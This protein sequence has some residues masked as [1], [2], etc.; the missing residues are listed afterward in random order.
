MKSILGALA[1]L[2]LWSCVRADPWLTFDP[3]GTG[4][5]AKRIVL[6]AGDEEYRSEEALPQL[7]RILSQR[8]GFHCDVLVSQDADGTVNPNNQ[9]N[10]PGMHLLDGADLVIVE[11][12]FRELPDADMKHFADYLDS[13]RPMMLLRTAN[14]SFDYS[15][16]KR[17]PYARFAYNAP[18]GGVGGLTVG[19]SWTYHHGDHRH[20]ATLGLLDGKNHAH[21]ILKGVHDVFGLTDVYGVNADFPAD[22]TV[23]MYGQVLKGM[24]PTDPPNTQKPI[25]PL[26]WLRDYHSASGKTSKMFCSTIGAAIDLK[27][28]DLRRLFINASLYLTGRPVPDHADAALVGA[29][30]PSMYGFNEFK[31]GVRLDDLR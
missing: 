22:A 4:A 13:G 3:P 2:S 1:A 28:D 5:G 9:T 8:H 27:S 24:S 6:L 12:R 18:G 29:Y 19:E 30:D 26:V 31:R 14:H 11:F 25:M 7:A 21:P 17:S 10:V 16:N 20:E 15:R 23:L